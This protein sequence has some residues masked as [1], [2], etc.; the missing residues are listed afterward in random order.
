MKAKVEEILKDVMQTDEFYDSDDFL[1]DGLLDSLG[2]ITIV[3]RLEKE[4]SVMIEGSDVVADAFINVDSICALVSK[5]I[6]RT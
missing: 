3:V 2:V 4:F 1:S 6:E 5:Y